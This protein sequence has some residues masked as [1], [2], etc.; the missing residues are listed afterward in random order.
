MLW[1]C[2]RF[3][4]PGKAHDRLRKQGS[5]FESGRRTG[6]RR[7]VHGPV[8][9]H[10]GFIVDFGSVTA[11]RIW[12]RLTNSGDRTFYLIERTM[13]T[14]NP[15]FNAKTFAGLPPATSTAPM[16]VRG[17]I[18]K[19]FFLLLLLAASATWTW[20][21]AANG[22]VETLK[23]L[24]IIGLFGGL[25]TAIITVFKKNIAS[26]TAPLYALL[27]GLLLGAISSFLELAY[28]GIVI[29]AVGLTFA[30]LL[31]MLV[32]YRTGIITVT[33]RFRFGVV[34]A[35]GGIALLYFITFILGLFGVAVP[36][37]HSG[38]T[39]GIILSLVI[40]TIASLN[41]I[42]D[43][44]FIEKGVEAG[45]PKYME[46]YGAFGLMVTLVWLYLELLR[47]LGRKR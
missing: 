34:A 31:A 15:A 39:V 44:D 12:S 30:I 43:F 21:L 3:G 16:T 10:A 9:P 40:I 41:L 46:W 33:D 1:E 25:G 27:E 13:R 8:M 20:D 4:C 23:P 37:L 28:P 24:M 38:G 7:E 6:H 26:Y 36:Y 17:T 35:T 47:L 22:N 42:L 5:G 18:D 19:S 45:A 29:Q 2:Y 14:S 11:R 32:I